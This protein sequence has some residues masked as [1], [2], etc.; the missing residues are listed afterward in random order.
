MTLLESHEREALVLR[1]VEE[2]EYHEIAAAQSIPIGTVKWRVF[3][4]KKKLGAHLK[5][6]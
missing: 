6:L 3:S 2:W 1:F 5:A 4:A